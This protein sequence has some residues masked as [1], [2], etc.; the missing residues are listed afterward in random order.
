[1]GVVTFFWLRIC[2]S[3]RF[4]W[5]SHGWC[6]STHEWRLLFLETIGPIEP[7]IR[8]KMCLHPVFWVSVRQHGVFWGNNLKIG[9]DT[10]PPP[11]PRPPKVIFTFIAWR[12]TLKNGHA[13]QKK[14]SENIAFFKKIVK[15]KMFESSM[16][17]KRL[18]WFLSPISRRPCPPQ[19]GFSQFSGKILFFSKN[20]FY[21]KTFVT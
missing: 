21:N 19:M 8:G 5:N 2:N 11:P 18:Y 9:F 20:L 12:P 7:Q 16:P 3:N 15:W 6:K 13:P 4:L 1:M 10:P 14:Y 17:A